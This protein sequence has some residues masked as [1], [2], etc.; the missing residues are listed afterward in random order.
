MYKVV[1]SLLTQITQIG[2]MEF[3]EFLIKMLLVQIT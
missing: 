3:L 2:I 1:E